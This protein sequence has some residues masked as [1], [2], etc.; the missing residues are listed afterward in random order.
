MHL[1][2]PFAAASNAGRYLPLRLR[3]AASTRQA[4]FA[5]MPAPLPSDVAPATI[6]AGHEGVI[7]NVAFSD[8]GAARECGLLAV[9]YIR[10]QPR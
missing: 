9:V 5:L 2:K 7:F 4:R 6:L 1:W 10:C 8:D 3:R